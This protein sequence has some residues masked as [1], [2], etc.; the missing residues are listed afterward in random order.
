MFSSLAILS[1]LAIVVIT[2]GT[3][4]TGG[5]KIRTVLISQQ[6]KN[7]MATMPPVF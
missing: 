5:E 6:I 7:I 1:V 3:M 4:L 2:I